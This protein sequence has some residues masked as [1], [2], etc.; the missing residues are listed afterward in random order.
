MSILN[1][2]I[3][4]EYKGEHDVE[5]KRGAYTI[6][7]DKFRLQ[8]AD[9]TRVWHRLISEVLIP[10]VVRQ[11][12]SQGGE[13]RRQWAKLAPTTRRLYRGRPILQQTGMLQ[14]S[15]IGGPDHVEEVEPRRMKWGSQSPYALFHQTGTGIKLGDPTPRGYEF[16]PSL[17]IRRGAAHA[18]GHWE[19]TEKGRGMP[20]RPILDLYWLKVRKLGKE[21]SPWNDKMMAIVRHE[22]REAAR[23]AGM[24]L[25]G[26]E[27]REAPGAGAEALRIGDIAMGNV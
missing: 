8:M 16:K 25:M 1:F 3:G 17:R 26:P 18:G 19:P 12:R 7:H 9:W 14:L 11:F 15:F 6:W 24:A 5:P 23:R 22:L 21:Y 4:W 27:E 20:Q 10:Y 2:K 13:G